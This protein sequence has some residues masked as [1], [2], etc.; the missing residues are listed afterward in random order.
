M[1]MNLFNS[2]GALALVGLSVSLTPSNLNAHDMRHG[3]HRM[4]GHDH[5]CARLPHGARCVNYRG[6][7]CWA[8]GGCYYRSHPLGGYVLIQPSYETVVVKQ[9]VLEEKVVV[10]RPVVKK[11]VQEEEVVEETAA[12]E[13]P[14]VE[15][16]VVEQPAVEETVVEE[17]AATPVVEEELEEEDTVLETLPVGAEVVVIGGERCWLRDG[18]YYRRCGHGYK[19]CHPHG[20]GK[21]HNHDGHSTK[22]HMDHGDKGHMPHQTK[23]NNGMGNH[24]PHQTKNHGGM[25]MG[26]HPHQMG[27]KHDKHN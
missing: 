7:R 24:M 17:A 13:Q 12:V 3:E 11:V 22:G 26:G 18:V 6:E 9:P 19:A 8:A 4:A 27:G 15:E 23:N 10:K 14:V 2:F 20:N 5:H 1:K 25:N 16:R 21:W